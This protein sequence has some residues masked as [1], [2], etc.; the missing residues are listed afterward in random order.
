MNYIKS[1]KWIIIFF[2]PFIF[3]KFTFAQTNSKPQGTGSGNN[4]TALISGIVHDSLSDNP[5]EYANVVLYSLKDSQLVN[6]CI[7]DNKGKFFIEKV[8]PGKYF[9]KVSFMGYKTYKTN[10]VIT[11][12]IN[13][14]KMDV[15]YLK[16]ASSSMKEVTI[17]G[18]RPLIEYKLDKKVVNVDKNIN[19]A[20][21]TALDV[22]QN[23]PSVTVDF[24]GSVS[25]RGTTNVTILIDGR[26]SGLTGT[27]LEQI[28]ASAIE[29]I[30]IITNPSAKFNPE[31]MGGILNIK[32][33]KKK[34]KGL[35]GLVSANIGTGNKYN[36][37]LNL[38]YSKNKFNFFGSY[39]YRKNERKGYGDMN[40]VTYY[41]DTAS[42]L[43][44][45]DNFLMER[46]SNNIKLG[47][48]YAITRKDKISFTWF[49]SRGNNQDNETSNSSIFD[50]N[51]IFSEYYENS[52]LED[53]H[54]QSF[55]Y[56]LNYKRTFARRYQEL[57][58]DII[59]ST[60]ADDE[61]SDI[62][63]QEFNLD[64]TP[65]NFTPNLQ[66][67][68]NNMKSKRL[69]IQMNYVHPLKGESKI[70]MGLQSI[71]RNND[72]D[73]YYK[74]FNYSD[75]QWEID[76]NFTNR[77]IYDDKVQA[78]YGTYSKVYKKLS[79]QAGLRLEGAFITA[80]SRSLNKVFHRDYF[81]AFPS[82][83]ITRK[84]E[85]AGQDVQLSYSRRINRPDMHSL[86]PYI[87]KSDPLS[88]RYGNP[89]LKP[90]YI[91]S[92]ELGH[93]KY[94]KST[95]LYTNLFYR[96]INDVIKRVVFLDSNGI[97]NMTA[98]NLSSGQSYGVEFVY[99]QKITK[100]W[101]ATAN[102]SYFR[103]IIK[104]DNS[105]TNLT[106]DNY[107]WTSSINTSMMLPKSIALQINGF[108]RGPI[109]QPQGE[110]KQMYSVD[111]ALKKDI[112]KEQGTI[113]FRLSDIFN[114]MKF[115]MVSK[116]EGFEGEYLRKRQTRV[117]YF[118]FTY[119]I[120]QGIKAQNR[121][122]GLDNNTNDEREFE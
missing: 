89:E 116:G 65:K 93:T 18:E 47:L 122:K 10:L 67:S 100:W 99:D 8:S 92:Y 25:M 120:N 71:N 81:S 49:Y 57:T 55:D 35:N 1:R 101:K 74:N 68:L 39:D 82:L 2:I 73:Y 26:P 53:G 54:D 91:N 32:L 50:E 30:E 96:Q 12:K 34:E 38:N 76:S 85:K 64:F 40:R 13:E 90:E 115:T 31:G 121:K 45:H 112:F 20:G 37:S 42:Y 105:N 98:D 83:H 94:W 3:T 46:L 110:M 66:N 79:A 107:S 95:S 59:Y 27:K 86:N 75:S 52:N 78:I 63:L 72:N 106:N 84:F 51:H 56:T 14:Y 48:D 80:D 118:G 70:E 58:A 87:D 29:S 97:I 36:G 113:T 9:L 21:G 111:I 114:T 23:V 62:K 88:Y 28:P 77:F 5:V 104:G 117:A 6:G 7:S 102:F 41:N 33:K 69:T 19:T 11:P 16:D 61:L 15:I 119:K 60:S 44:Q 103:T 22:L 17:I 43:I 108:Y 24:D 4:N 109:I